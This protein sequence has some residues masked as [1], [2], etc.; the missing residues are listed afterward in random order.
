MNNKELVQQLIPLWYAQKYW[1]EE[2][3]IRTFNL[4]AAEDLARGRKSIPG[5]NWM[6]CTHGVGVD[7]YRT[8]DTGGIDFDFN[9]PAPDSWRLQIFFKKQYNEGNLCYKSYRELFEDEDLACSVIKDV[10]G[11]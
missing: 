4:E 7:V 9:K 11:E 8:T 5:T 10:L 6:Y 1:A 3:L 2:L